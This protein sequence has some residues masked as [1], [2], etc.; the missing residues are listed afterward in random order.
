MAENALTKMSKPLVIKEQTSKPQL[1]TIPHPLGRLL[2]F[3]KQKLINVKK[4]MDT[5]GLLYTAYRTLLD[6]AVASFLVR[7]S[8]DFQPTNNDTEIYYSLPKLGLSLGL[9]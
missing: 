1:D 6:M 3:L 2:D 5:L 4:G 7:L 8:L 9:F